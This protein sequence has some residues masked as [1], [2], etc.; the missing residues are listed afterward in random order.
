MLGE[1]S[2]LLWSLSE[3]A[4]QLGGISKSTVRRLIQQGQLSSC[5]VG[6]RRLCI[7]VAS[8]IAYVERIATGLAEDVAVLS[9]EEENSARVESIACKGNNP[10]HI[11]EK[12]HRI[13]GSNTPTQAANQ[14]TAVL[15]Q[16]TAGKPRHSK[17]NG[18]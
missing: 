1:S 2:L 9:E 14:L 10:C 8:V 7:P 15:A 3:V 16:L 18:A 17:Q 5:R 6:A 12:I 4:Q 13:G 11:A